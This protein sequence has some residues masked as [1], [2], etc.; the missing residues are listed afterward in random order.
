L[1]EGPGA[2]HN[3][4]SGMSQSSE[5]HRI[6]ERSL[7]RITSSAPF[8]GALCRFAVFRPDEA[9]ATCAT[10]GAAV[11]YNPGYLAERS[12]REVDRLLVH[13]VLH[14]ALL[15][16]HERGSRDPVRWNVAADLAIEEILKHHGDLAE[17]GHG[18]PWAD[19]GQL[20]AAELYDGVA[21]VA[22]AS[23]ASCFHEPTGQLE[24]RRSPESLRTYWARA[25]KQAQAF[26]SPFGNLY[27]AGMDRI[28]EPLFD[29]STAE[30]LSLPQPEG[31][32]DILAG[33]GDRHG[34]HEEPPLQ[35]ATC[36]A[37][38]AGARTAEQ[39]LAAFRWLIARTSP[40]WI[41]LWATRMMAQL[42]AT[43]QTG[44]FA[45]AVAEDA[46]LQAFLEGYHR[47]LVGLGAVRN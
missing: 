40:S 5:S 19:A 43:K 20:S 47:L 26:H 27:P 38:G 14:A 25:L 11:F 13:H 29:G 23:G 17:P 9:I 42:K 24:G 15:H 4:G 8:L 35:Y 32:D 18:L 7:L 21:R 12:L 1:R 22:H 46:A 16:L 28:L 39:A 36:I 44:V 30:E 10:D 41:A 31:I 34:F 45:Q 6:I 37:L 2:G 3:E 33:E